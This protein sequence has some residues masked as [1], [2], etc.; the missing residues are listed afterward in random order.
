V[1]LH[2][3]ELVFAQRPEGHEWHEAARQARRTWNLVLHAWHT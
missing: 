2:L 1:T 3:L